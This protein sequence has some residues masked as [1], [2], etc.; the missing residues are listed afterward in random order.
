MCPLFAT[1][2]DFEVAGLPCIDQSMAGQKKYEEGKTGTVFCCHAKRHVELETPLIL[3]ENVQA[4]LPE[5]L[6]YLI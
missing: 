5:T 1:T 2:P 6:F 4:R 3:M